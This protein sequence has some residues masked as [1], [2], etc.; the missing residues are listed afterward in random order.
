[1]KKVRVFLTVAALALAATGTFASRYQL[2][3]FVDGWEYIQGSGG[4]ADVCR[5][6][7]DLCTTNSSTLC[8]INGHPV[9]NAP[10]GTNCGT[11]LHMP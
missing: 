1:M 4:E 7:N 11:Q 5:V 2:D 10:S 6:K 3:T 8:S 9:G